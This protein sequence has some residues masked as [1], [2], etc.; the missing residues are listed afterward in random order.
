LR[1]R[2]TLPTPAASLSV[3]SLYIRG[4]YRYNTHVP[5]QLGVY[6]KYKVDAYKLTLF[7]NVKAQGPGAYLYTDCAARESLDTNILAPPPQ[8]R[9]LASLFAPKF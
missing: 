4:A 8:N 3:T 5:D 7:T 6:K 1:G 2:S 9:R